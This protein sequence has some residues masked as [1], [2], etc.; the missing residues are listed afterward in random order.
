MFDPLT[1]AH[2]HRAADTA[3][4]YGRRREL[5]IF[6]HSGR[7]TMVVIVSLVMPLEL[8]DRSERSGPDKR[9]GKFVIGIAGFSSDSTVYSSHVLAGG[10]LL[11]TAFLEVHTHLDSA[12]SFSLCLCSHGGARCGW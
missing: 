4:N 9:A 3:E 7:R 12:K 6:R 10:A 1:P 2:P 11:E 8:L 5:R